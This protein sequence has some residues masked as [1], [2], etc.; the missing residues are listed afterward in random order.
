MS[1]LLSGTLDDLMRGALEQDIV[2]NWIE[3]AR[4]I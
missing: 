3:I 1:C 4:N 2:L